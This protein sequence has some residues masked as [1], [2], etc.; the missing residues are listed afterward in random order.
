[1]TARK[2]RLRKLLHVQEQLKA[3]H[4]TRRAGFVAKAAS[5]DEEAKELIA[6]FDQPDSLSGL[7]PDVYNRRIANAFVERDINAGLARAE[8]ARVATATARTNMVEKAW[9]EAL[10]WDER[11]KGDRERLE[12]IEQGRR[13]N[14]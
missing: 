1:M 7:F 6:R 12:I 4:E 5:A 10:R 8:T 11:E 9:R 2:D 3:L 13:D 14:G